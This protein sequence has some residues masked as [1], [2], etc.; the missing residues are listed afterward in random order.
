MLEE[1][2]EEL[3]LFKVTLAKLQEDLT[4]KENQTQKRELELENKHFSEV[5]KKDDLIIELENDLNDKMTTIGDIIREREC[6]LNHN[7]ALEEE[8]QLSQNELLNTNEKYRQFNIFKSLFR[9]QLDVSN[10]ED[11]FVIK[12]ESLK[13]SERALQWQVEELK[14]RLSNKNISRENLNENNKSLLEEIRKIAKKS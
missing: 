1:R 2:D 4:K 13:E 12:E 6:L 9:Y 14:Q 10:L 8:L 3:C 7:K 5:K 11:E